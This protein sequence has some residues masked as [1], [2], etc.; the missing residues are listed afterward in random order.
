MTS[1]QE[2]EQA[3]HVARR[4]IEAGI[5]VFAAEPDG[6]G[7]HLLPAKW[8]LTVPSMMWIEKW[9]PG[10]GLGAVGG[11][12]GDFLDEDPRHGGDES[13][14]ELLALS[15]MP[16]AY[17]VAETPS[18]G[19]HYLIAPLHEGRMS[20]VMPGLDYQGGR[21]D[22]TGRAFV[23]I[24]PTVRASKVTGEMVAYRWTQEPDLEWLAEGG[25]ESGVMV[26]ARVHAARARKTSEERAA[27]T[28]PAGLRR[29]TL[30]EARTYCSI[31]LDRLM[32]AQIGE[33]EERANDA[34]VTL[35]HFVPDIFSEDYAFA[36]LSAALAVTA[37]D[38]ATWHA[39]KFRD[40]IAGRNGR[41]P[42]DWRAEPV[43]A[44]IAPGF[45][46][47]PEG[48]QS[49]ADWLEGQLVT[50]DDLAAMP[51]P[52][53]LVYGLLNLDTESW[54]IG[55]AG[56]FKSFVAL[57][58]AACVGSGQSWQGHRVTQG[59]VI[60]IAAEGARGMTLRTRAWQQDRARSMDGVAFLPL[61]VQVKK[62]EDWAALVEVCRRRKPSLII[63][64]TQHRIMKGLEENS[65]S[66]FAYVTEALTALR[67]ATGACVLVIHHT[68]RNGQDAR[69]TSAIDG[70]QDTE[71]KVERMMPRSSMRVKLI[72][73]KQKDMAEE[74]G[75]TELKL[76]V[77][78][79]GLD[80]ET[81]VMLSSLVLDSEWAA[82][83]P[84]QER[85]IDVEP[86]KGLEPEEWSAR[87]VARQAKV[88][89][90]I[91]QVL[92]DH[93]GQT[94]ITEATVRKV[95]TD[96]W[97]APHVTTWT[98]SWQAVKDLD[99]TVN[100]GGERWALDGV[101]LSELRDA[102]Q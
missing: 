101:I 48:Q 76:K 81:S 67:M 89:R 84:E 26:A 66:D 82:A 72:E 73:D 39:D 70:A 37:Y 19:R 31:T 41:A 71:L 55:A 1:G 65:A 87:V 92:A 102:S 96:R 69:G 33:I 22:G 99:I 61:P 56:S 79:L 32:A 20:R 83:R 25:D 91:L 90:R 30:D 52:V 59:D 10:W 17:G 53:P 46:E 7:G 4:L 14:A 50:A 35:S 44:V 5:P 58:I 12:A 13:V 63:I 18:G 6:K 3:L 77:V 45:E 60:Y 51:A 54:L 36:A 97:E 9:R 88:K 8:Q 100:T 24:A 34:A 27:D 21:P 16:R 42:G 15:Q 94:G 75:G 93:A 23:W 11:H 86:W 38:A 74:D 2:V 43:A 57:D 47:A 80:P 68:G 78:E 98:D 28:R 29:F 64:D 49:R 95:V 62:T 85:E 40:V